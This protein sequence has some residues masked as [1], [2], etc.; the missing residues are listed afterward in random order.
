MRGRDCIRGEADDRH[1]RRKPVAAVHEVEEVRAPDDRRPRPPSAATGAT[2]TSIICATTIA[3]GSE[4]HDEAHRRR[5]AAHVV[6]ERDRGDGGDAPPAR[7]R[8]TPASA[9]ARRAPRPSMPAQDRQAADAR[10]VALVQRARVRR[11]V[12]QSA[13]MPPQQR[14][15]GG[16]APRR[17]ARARQRGSRHRRVTPRRRVPARIR[18]ASAA[19]SPLAASQ[20]GGGRP[21]YA[22]GNRM[23]SILRRGEPRTI[24][25]CGQL[26][27]RGIM[28][29]P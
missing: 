21:R 9:A 6:G 29:L 22:A 12:R 11:G 18:V 8:R 2:A 20:R 7:P 26:F 28:G 3:R 27:P 10:H 1:R 17:Q 23:K 4:L 13:R 24:P 15:R 16:R 5:H 14:E 19:N 25:N